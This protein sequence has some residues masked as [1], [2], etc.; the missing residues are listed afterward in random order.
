MASQRKP[1]RHAGACAAILCIAGLAGC[2]Q[3]DSPTTQASPPDSS[4][5]EPASAPA[6]SDVPA[7]TAPS[8]V[9]D[10]PNRTGAD[11]GVANSADHGKYLVDATGQTLYM[12]EKDSKGASSCYDACS[13]QWPPL[14]SPKGTPKALDPA[15]E[16]GAIVNIQRT[17]GTVQVTYNGHPL[18]HYSKDVAPG[19]INGQGVED[20]FGEWYMLTP[21]GEPMES[22]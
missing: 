21:A 6:T 10:Q 3:Y 5:R 19:Q 16:A 4:A 17:D 8:A 12:L 1:M 14:L 11:L 13:T 15:L 18:Y 7:A 22:H 9:P 2:K 20:Q